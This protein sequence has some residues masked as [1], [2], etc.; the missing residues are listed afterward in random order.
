MLT[1]DYTNK[2]LGL[3]DC[4][5]TN[6]ENNS[7]EVIIHLEM[8][9]KL[10]SC[11]C[12]KRQTKRIHDYRTQ[13]IKDTS[14]QGKFTFLLLKRRRYSC[15]H[16]HKRFMEDTPFVG[17]YQRIT[18]RLIHLCLRQF[19]E[20]TSLKNKA[21]NLG[22]SSSQIRRIYSG[23]DF[24]S[25]R[26][27]PEI[28][29]IDEFKG[30]ANGNKYQCIL[31]DP[32]HHKVIDVLPMRS[33]SSL[34]AYFRQFKNRDT[35]KVVVMDMS[36]LFRAVIQECFP[37]AVIVADKYHVV[38]QVGWAFEDVRINIQKQFS[39][40]GRLLFK[41]S[42]GV[43]LKHPTKLSP[44]E[45]EKVASLLSYSEP[46]AIAYRLRAQFLYIMKCTDYTEARHLLSRW[47][48]EAQN[49]GL[50]KFITCAS[51][52]IKWSEPILAYFNASYT[53]G[54]TEGINNKTK[55]IKRNAFGIRNFKHLRNRILYACCP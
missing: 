6:I 8:E 26:I 35:V 29:S 21:K 50:K 19:Q 43:L 28:L 3:E 13:R 31:T 46:L 25:P 24:P 33:K 51:T 11:P 37:H 36:N 22:L 7:N 34:V 27:L 48:L 39:D 1:T 9:R 14:V 32:E 2:L 5:I 17:K 54:Y 16:C 4:K 10:H 23:L 45:M 12:C 52:F 30:D 41:R 47:V 18:K 55:V 42:R 40:E 44:E 20:T 53:N 49:S 15:M 38:R